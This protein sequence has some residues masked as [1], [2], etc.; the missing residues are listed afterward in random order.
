VAATEGFALA[1]PSDPKA[2]FPVLSVTGTGA[3]R[4]IVTR[5]ESP[6]GFS[7][8]MR[9]VDCAKHTLRHLATGDTK[10]EMAT[11]R[12]DDPIGPIVVRSIAWHVS[13]EA[14]RRP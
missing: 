14:C 3:L 13:A 8:S 6:S 4:Q 9:E 12:F 2:V 1:V 10:A 5:L 11:N 7:Y